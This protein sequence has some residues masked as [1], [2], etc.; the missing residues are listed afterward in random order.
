MSE[1]MEVFLRT[2]L[3]FALF[4]AIARLLGKQTLSYLTLNHFIAA[5][6]LGSITA[7]L[8]FNLNIETWHTVLA[9][10]T[11]FVTSILILF[12]TVK[13]RKARRWISGEPTVLIEDGT[14]LEKNMG[15]AKFTIDNLNQLLREKGVFDINEVQ[16][17]IL[18]T[19]GG[20]SVQKKP[21]FRMLTRQD[22]GI[23][24]QKNDA[25][26][27]VEL[28][29][30]KQVLTQN[31]MQNNLSEAWLQEELNKK[32]LTLSEVYYAVKGT[33]GNLYF[34]C[35]KDKLEAPIDKE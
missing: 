27:P 9:M 21:P 16:Y 14:I 32:N 12:W 34:D 22:M 15:K 3:A 26:F 29:M 1:L 6:T 30:E 33:N 35:Y 7:N 8:A 20:I 11:F 23:A 25:K 2:L 4:I 24:S 31:L 17:A 13:S 5:A 18:E 28:I 10:I 19:N